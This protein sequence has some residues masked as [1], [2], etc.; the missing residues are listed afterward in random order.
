[1]IVGH[2]QA[3]SRIASSY[4][5]NS[6]LDLK[7]LKHFG[8]QYKPRRTLSVIEVNWFPPPFGWV[9]INTGGAWKQ[10]SG[11]CGYGAVFRDY[12][13]EFIG[14]FASNHN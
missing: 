12:R 3:A 14:A 13:G 10:D 9:K 4:M 7:V 2:V 8:V 6:L 11:R 5:T 1:L